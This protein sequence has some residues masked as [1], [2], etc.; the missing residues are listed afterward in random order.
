MISFLDLNKINQP[1]ENAFQN[2]LRS[3]LDCGWCILVDEVK[4]FENFDEYCQS[5][6]CIGIERMIHYP[7]A[8]HKQKALKNWNLLSFPITEKIHNEI[9]SLPISPLMSTNE[10]DFIIKKINKWTY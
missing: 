8:P 1:Y 10:I 5:K 4:L 7:I 9:L 6:N 2:K 3:I